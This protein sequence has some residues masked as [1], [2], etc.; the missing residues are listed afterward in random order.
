M[1]GLAQFFFWSLVFLAAYNAFWTFVMVRILSRK[2]P[3]PAEDATLPKAAV[4]L[5]LRGA[6]PNLTHSL[7]RLLRQDY[8][9]YKLFIAVDSE[10]DPAWNIVR[11]TIAELGATNVVVAPLRQ[12]LKTCSLKCSSLV[13]L[14]GDVDDS[15][16]VIVLADADLESHATWLRELIAPMADPMVGA[17]FGNR[18][19]LPGQG[20]M[21]S[22]VRQL[23]NG[24][25]IVVMLAAQIPWGGSLA[26]RSSVVKAGNLRD[27]WAHAIVD[28]GPVRT[29][30][31]QQRMKLQFV[32]SLLMA[33]RE[34][35]DLAFAH[36]F[37]RRQLTWTSTYVRP[38][39]PALLAYSLGSAAM[40]AGAVAMAIVCAARGDISEATLFGS[41]ALILSTVVSVLWFILDGSARS[42]VRRQGELAIPASQSQLFRIPLAL[43]L[44]VCIHLCASL[45][46]T[47]ARRIEWRGVKY[48]IQGPWKVRMLEDTAIAVTPNPQGVSI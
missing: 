29:V 48:E 19:F 39:W 22:L 10:K 2:A 5:C 7:R 15:F 46:A 47:F 38:W 4:L 44:A 26:I 27:K 37:L 41:G 45:S 30:V 36:Q 42:V 9:D 31:K 23:C 35:C 25:S 28:D 24:P 6:D 17:T 33:N 32:P 18:W 34:E 12:R 40:W 8:P 21:G 16:E 43:S 11:Q 14:L 13:Q 20:W 1:L 3:P